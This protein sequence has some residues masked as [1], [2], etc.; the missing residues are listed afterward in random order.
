MLIAAS[1]ISPSILAPASIFITPSSG[2]T[3]SFS[4]NG[5]KCAANS[6]TSILHGKLGIAPSSIIF[7]SIIMLE[8]LFLQL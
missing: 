1:T 3:P 5:E 7:L 6:L 8:Q 4:V 2:N